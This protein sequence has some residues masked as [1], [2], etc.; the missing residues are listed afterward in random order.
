MCLQNSMH[1]LAKCSK[2]NC[3]DLMNRNYISEVI[4][5]L[6][7]HNLICLGIINQY[8]MSIAMCHDG[9]VGLNALQTRLLRCEICHV[10]AFLI[11]CKLRHSK[12]GKKSTLNVSLSS[13]E[14]DVMIDPKKH[15]AFWCRVTYAFCTHAQSSVLPAQFGQREK[16]TATKSWGEIA[17][18]MGGWR[19]SVTEGLG[20]FRWRNAACRKAFLCPWNIFA[21]FSRRRTSAWPFGSASWI[22]S[23]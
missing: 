1:S 4:W 11:Q 22:R 15:F 16:G 17:K 2:V 8:Y 9:R 12:N 23:E 10:W 7:T 19:V 5:W 6:G 13:F 3:R 21:P 14:A 18:G 20:S